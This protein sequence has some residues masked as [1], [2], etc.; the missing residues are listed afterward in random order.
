MPQG[1]STS[2]EGGDASMDGG[3]VLE[4]A[5]RE[6]ARK[7]LQAALVDEVRE[8]PHCRWYPIARDD[9]WAR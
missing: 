6:G 2:D 4:E 9:R 5:A 8:H 7:V 1:K 3:S